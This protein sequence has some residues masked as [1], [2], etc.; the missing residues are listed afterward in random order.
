MIIRLR[1]SSGG[2]AKT[3]FQRPQGRARIINFLRNFVSINNYM[4]IMALFYAG[5]L[6][7]ILT[8]A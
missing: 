2:Q 6:R 3:A 8:V 4:G 1:L 5:K 7:F